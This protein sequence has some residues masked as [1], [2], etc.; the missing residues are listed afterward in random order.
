MKKIILILIAGCVVAAIVIMLKPVKNEFQITGY[1]ENI[2][3]GA[4]INLYRSD[5]DLLKTVASDTVA[6]GK[7]ILQDTIT[8][9]IRRLYLT[10]DGSGFP[11]RLMY[12]WVAPGSKIN[13]TGN[14]KLYPTWRVESRIAEQKYE[15]EF[16]QQGLPQ[17]IKL[18][19]LSAKETDLIINMFADTTLTN[20]QKRD[21]WSEIENIR[22]IENKYRDS[23][24]FK[25]VEY[26]KDAPKSIVWFNRMEQYAEYQQYSENKELIKAIEDLYHSRVD[27]TDKLTDIGKNIAEYYNI[28]ALVDVGDKMADGIMYDIEGTQRTLSELNGRYILLDFWSQGCG[29]CIQS[30]PELEEIINNYTGVLEVVSISED[31]KDSWQEFVKKRD[32]KGNQW[33]ELREGR[34][35]LAA[36]Y[37]VNSIPHYVLISP[38]GVIQSKWTGY[39]KNSLINRLKEEIK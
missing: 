33:N 13:I 22:Q 38:E 37:K 3:D 14:N 10:V 28:G 20:E 1:L 15:N 34:T 9:T 35:G 31:G 21:I 23:I 5:D 12:I 39:A 18:L 19:E 26:M 30:I 2:P 25:V 36:Q 11:N 32:L 4:I 29:Y 16:I 6:E 8:S 24:D 7:F 17:F 27:E